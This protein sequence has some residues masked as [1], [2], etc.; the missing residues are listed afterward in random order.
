M[1]NTWVAEAKV[2]ILEMFKKG[3]TKL[4]QEIQMLGMEP[5]SEDMAESKIQFY[6]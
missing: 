5:R 2:K 3:E 1:I 6:L 4:I